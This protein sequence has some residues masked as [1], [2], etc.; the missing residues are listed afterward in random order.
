MDYLDQ[1][2]QSYSLSRLQSSNIH[3]FL[4]GIVYLNIITDIR[5]CDSL[6]AFRRRL[7]SF[8]FDS[9]FTP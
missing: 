4:Y 6:L 7:K 2:S 9:A 1:N 5:N 8:L 3:L